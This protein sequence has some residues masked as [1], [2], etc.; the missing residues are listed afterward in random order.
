MICTYSKKRADGD[1]L[2]P[3]GTGKHANKLVETKGKVLTTRLIPSRVFFRG[4]VIS[5]FKL[6]ER[7]RIQALSKVEKYIRYNSSVI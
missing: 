6:L 2:C 4:I 3:S 1:Y 7:R 5:A